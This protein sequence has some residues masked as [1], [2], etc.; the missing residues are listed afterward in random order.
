M[1]DVGPQELD[2][3]AL[4]VEELRD[5]VRVL[6]Q[7]LD[8]MREAAQWWNQNAADLLAGTLPPTVGNESASDAVREVV[9][10]P[11]Q[12]RQRTMF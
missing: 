2:E 12:R 1:F 8:E 5:E 7:V 11:A 9:S 3:L 4:T 6:R 10:I